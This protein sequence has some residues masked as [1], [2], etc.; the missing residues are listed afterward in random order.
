MRSFPALPGRSLCKVSPPV[1]V[2]K[3]RQYLG[4]KSEKTRG[5]ADAF[6]FLSGLVPDTHSKFFSGNFPLLSLLV[7]MEALIC[8]SIKD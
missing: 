4:K 7:G 8:L 6:Y 3:E 2:L 1:G 5:W